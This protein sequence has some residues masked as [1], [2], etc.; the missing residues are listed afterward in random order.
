MA[1]R[2]MPLFCPSCNVSNRRG[3]WYCTACG[4][5]L[6]EDPPDALGGFGRSECLPGPRHRPAIPPVAYLVALF[7]IA[8]LAMAMW[9]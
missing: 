9:L 1:S 2:Q 7:V 6:T 3:M 8:V 5:M 4:A